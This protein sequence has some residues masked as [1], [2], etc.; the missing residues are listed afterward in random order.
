[1]GAFELMD[2]VGLDVGLEIQKSFDALSFG[3]PRWRPSP[4]MANR[5]AAGWHGRK[6]GRGWYVYED[7]A[8]YRPEDPPA[9]K[10]GGGEQRLVVVAGELPIADAVRELALAA[11]WDAREPEDAEGEVPFLNVDCGADP[12][13]PPLE[14]GPL[15]LLCADASL[16]VL[17][18]GGGAA[19]FH[20][21]PP[22]G[23]VEL[24]RSPATTAAAA[25][26][27]EAFF[28]TLGVHIGWVGDAP[29]GVLG[30]I[31]AQLVNEAC[32]SLGE[33]VA[34]AQEI[35]EAM[36]LGLNH[37]RGPLTWAREIGLEHLL[38]LLDGL[39]AEYREERYR[40]APL[41]RRAVALGAD[42]LGA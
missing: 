22:V 6:A 13:G 8:P 16:A 41:L 42:D 18:A 1:M 9:P 21:L 11:G 19:G 38:A 34:G 33:G 25:R 2:L 40:A 7:G 5:V 10:P 31:A 23:F 37:P 35:D 3:E 32:F 30:R 4:L 29:G 26:A 17:D 12:E 28:G 27:S 14:G 39:Y 20:A 36:V 15:A 24:L